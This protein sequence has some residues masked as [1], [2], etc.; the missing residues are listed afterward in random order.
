MDGEQ[1]EVIRLLKE[2][3]TEVRAV[4]TE[5]AKQND[6]LRLLQYDVEAS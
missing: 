1:D 2:V 5:L 4:K 3:L 6:V